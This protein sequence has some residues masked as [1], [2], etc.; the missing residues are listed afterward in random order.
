MKSS[1]GSSIVIIIPYLKKSEINCRKSRIR[2]I[3]SSN[4]QLKERLNKNM[5]VI[6]VTTRELAHMK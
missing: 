6:P 3:N 2:N 5:T 4:I 1:L